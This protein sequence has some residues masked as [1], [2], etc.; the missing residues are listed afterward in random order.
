MSQ[1]ATARI[2]GPDEA[3]ALEHC[4]KLGL[5]AFKHERLPCFGARLIAS[6]GARLLDNRRE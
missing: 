6:L 4:R 1:T 5:Q 2:L 3:C